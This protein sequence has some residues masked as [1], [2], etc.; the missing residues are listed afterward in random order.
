V[1]LLYVSDE[2]I[3]SIIVVTKIGEL[4]TTPAVTINLS[5]LRHTA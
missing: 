1:W 3:V 4:E 2:S 5:M